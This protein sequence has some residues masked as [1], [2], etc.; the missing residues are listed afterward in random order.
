MHSYYTEDFPFMVGDI[1]MH[2]AK[3]CACLYK[4]LYGKHRHE[5]V[6]KQLSK[7][8]LSW[9]VLF[10][11]SPGGVDNYKLEYKRETKG[12]KRRGKEE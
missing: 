3:W 1:F 7:V 5:S 6:R 9:N 8:C 4:E 2:N 10:K 12:K 11:P